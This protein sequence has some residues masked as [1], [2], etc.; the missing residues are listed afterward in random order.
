[1]SHR[2]D[3]NLNDVAPRLGLDISH[4]TFKLGNVA[5]KPRPRCHILSIQLLK[6]HPFVNS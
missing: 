3:L 4:M 5:P 2:L 6:I 1:M